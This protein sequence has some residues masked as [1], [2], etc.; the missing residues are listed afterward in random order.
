[1]IER[2]VPDLVV[3]DAALARREDPPG[4]QGIVGAAVPIMLIVE[5]QERSTSIPIDIENRS[6]AVIQRPLTPHALIGRARLLLRK[7]AECDDTMILATAG[8][9]I[10]LQT[11]RISRNG[12]RVDI[13]PIEFR[14]LCSLLRCSPRVLSRQELISAAWP[15]GVF[16]D[17]RT[18]NIHVGRLRRALSTQGEPNLIRTVRS[19]GYSFDPADSSIHDVTH[20]DVLAGMSGSMAK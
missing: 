3:L 16:V 15:P 1:M 6:I 5:S 2:E 10:N 11:Y 12:R 19:A 8:V 14:L 13:G 7:P 4:F 9:E 20:R 17:P 18:V